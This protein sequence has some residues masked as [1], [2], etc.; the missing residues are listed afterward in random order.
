MKLEDDED[1]DDY[2]LWWSKEIRNEERENSSVGRK[3]EVFK[4][5]NGTKSNK[6][7]TL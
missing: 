5:S 6:S 7:M 1:E 4:V 3:S 2:G